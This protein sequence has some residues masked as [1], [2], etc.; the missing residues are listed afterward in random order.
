MKNPFFQL[1]NTLGFLPKTHKPLTQNPK[2]LPALV[3]TS[4]ERQP[5]EFES[6]Q[7]PKKQNQMDAAGK[8]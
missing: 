7:L 4:R 1:E 2:C 6:A 5:I 8:K 3:V